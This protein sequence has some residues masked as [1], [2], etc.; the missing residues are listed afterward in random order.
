MES[1]RFLQMQYIYKYIIILFLL[2]S[3]LTCTSYTLHENVGKVIELV[4]C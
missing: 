3:F 2:P 4:I 1:L